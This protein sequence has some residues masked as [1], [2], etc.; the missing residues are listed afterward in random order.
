MCVKATLN[1]PRAW[2]TLL[3]PA[4]QYSWYQQHWKLSFPKH[5]FYSLCKCLAVWGE[6]LSPSNQIRPQNV[7]TSA[8]VW[9]MLFNWSNK[10][11]HIKQMV[12]RWTKNRRGPWVAFKEKSFRILRQE[13]KSLKKNQMT[14]NW[15]VEWIEGGISEFKDFCRMEAGWSY[16]FNSLKSTLFTPSTVLTKDLSTQT[17]IGL[18]RVKKISSTWTRDAWSY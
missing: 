3:L 14:D 9:N 4:Y 1:L 15:T 12:S 13:I 8:R 6:Q 5:F 2:H 18:P 10:V 7:K 11:T 16:H 17:R